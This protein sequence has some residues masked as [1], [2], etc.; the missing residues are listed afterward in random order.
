MLHSRLSESFSI[1]GLS[2]LMAC[3]TP[4]GEYEDYLSVEPVRF[5]PCQSIVRGSCGWVPNAEPYP[6]QFVVVVSGQLY[7]KIVGVTKFGPPV[8][9]TAAIDAF[10][11]FAEKEVVSRKHC[12]TAKV[13][14]SSRRLVGSWRPSE[15]RMHVE[16]VP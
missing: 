16:C 6:R 15:M 9:S 4:R 5:V 12:S 3:T 14:E 7:R 8:T 13:P 10:A 1:I 2:S 11:T